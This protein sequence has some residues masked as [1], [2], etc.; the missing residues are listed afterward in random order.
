MRW[1]L[2]GAGIVCVVLANHLTG[3]RYL[4][5]DVH[6]LQVPF[7]PGSALLITAA[8]VFFIWGWFV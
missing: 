1:I 8:L 3:W 6:I 2:Y 4:R 7:K 5:Q